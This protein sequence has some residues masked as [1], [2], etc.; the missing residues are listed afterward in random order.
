MHVQKPVVSYIKLIRTHSGIGL[1]DTPADPTKHARS[2]RRQTKRSGRVLFNLG[3]GKQQHGAL[4]RRFDP[5]LPS[6][7]PMCTHPRDQTL[8][9]PLDTTARPDSRERLTHGLTTVR[10]HLRLDDFERLTEGRDLKQVHG[11]T[12]MSTTDASLTNCNVG[13]AETFF[14]GRHFEGF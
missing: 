8:V 5:R 1:S 6:A 13:P 3:G 10:G 12:Y 14:H 2:R 11:G 7:R 4:G 9:E